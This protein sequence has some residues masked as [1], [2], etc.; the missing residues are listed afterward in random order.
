MVLDETF[1]DCVI[2]C[3]NNHG[4][5]DAKFLDLMNKTFGENKIPCNDKG[6]HFF[7][8]SFALKIYAGLM[9]IKSMQEACSKKDPLIGYPEVQKVMTFKLYNRVRKHFRVTNTYE[10]LARNDPGYHPLQNVNWALA[11]L[12]RK[13]IF[14]D[15]GEVLCIDEDHVKNRS[16]KNAFKTREPE[17]PIREGWTVI[18]LGEAGENKGS[19]VLNDSVKCGKHTHTNTDK[20]KN[21]N[22]V[23]QGKMPSRRESQ[24]NP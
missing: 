17:K 8:G 11:Y 18:K 9:G 24:K 15:S 3:T 14:V 23:N 6:I 4:Q 5:R 10:L 21:Y 16:R 19:F 22:V 1:I 20:G 12:R 2:C 13:T 7:R